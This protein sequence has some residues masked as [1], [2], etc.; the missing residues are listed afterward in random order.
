MSFYD[1]W[2]SCLTNVHESLS[3]FNSLREKIP[4]RHEQDSIPDNGICSPPP[5]Q[6]DYQEFAGKKWFELE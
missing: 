2:N 5:N 1:S 3:L 6:L 4:G